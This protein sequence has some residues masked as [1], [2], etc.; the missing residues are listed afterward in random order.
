MDET[1]NHIAL[2]GSQPGAADRMREESLPEQIRS[3]SAQIKPI[4]EL[5]ALWADL[6]VVSENVD[7]LLPRLQGACEMIAQAWEAL[8]AQE[9]RLAG[10]HQHG[11]K[12]QQSME[13]AAGRFSRLDKAMTELSQRAG[14]L[15][16][17]LSAVEG[18]IEQGLTAQTTQ[19][20]HSMAAFS[21]TLE[22]SLTGTAARVDRLATNVSELVV[23]LMG[24]QVQA[25]HGRLERLDKRLGDTGDEIDAMDSKL[26]A[27]DAKLTGTDGKVGALANRI[28]RLDDHIGD[29]D[30][31]V[32][33]INEGI[34]SINERI[35]SIDWHMAIVDERTAP[36]DGRLGALE[37][38][39]I[40][41]VDGR[42]AAVGG[43]FTEKDGTVKAFGERLFRHRRPARR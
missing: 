42:M 23:D 38:K 13:A 39:L 31:R 22:Q 1:A 26:G 8:R 9:Q 24:G 2:G 19:L 41:A 5:P 7:Q 36:I 40:E 35:G 33:L 18:R 12:L 28:D 25:A 27:L 3:I 16:K 34:G 17:E 20:E 43:Q 4:A 32:G 15:D 37:T 14:Y 6:G 30:D 21:G 29:T 10:L 11:L